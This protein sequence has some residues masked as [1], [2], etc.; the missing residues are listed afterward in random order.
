VEARFVGSCV[1]II[2]PCH[3]EIS[4]GRGNSTCG[5]EC[6]LCAYRAVPCLPD[7]FKPSLEMI[8]LFPLCA[9]DSVQFPCCRNYTRMRRRLSHFRHAKRH[10]S[11]LAIVIFTLCKRPPFDCHGIVNVE[12]LGNRMRMI[13][14]SLAAS[15]PTSGARQAMNT[16]VTTQSSV[17]AM[18][19]RY[20]ADIQL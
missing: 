16:V 1:F 10:C 11:R 6:S 5:K 19:G 12:W 2:A 17:R 20:R 8:R 9:I 7:C 14:L 13:C 3:R 18:D 15:V 4:T